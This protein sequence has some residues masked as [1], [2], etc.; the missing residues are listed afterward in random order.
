MHCLTY[1]NFSHIPQNERLKE[2][3]ISVDGGEKQQKIL[4]Q[5]NQEKLVEQNL[6]KIRIAQMDKQIAKQTD[7]AYS[8]ERH[9]M[10]LE[11]AMTDRLIDI[12]SQV[13]LL[14]MKKKCLMEERAQMKADIGDRLMKIEQLKTRYELSM[15]LLGKNDDGSTVTAVQ[16]KIEMAQEKYL[17]LNEGNALNEKILKAENEVK[18]MENMLQLMNFSNDEY[19]KI[20]ETVTESSPEVKKM[21]TLQNNYFQ[22][23]TNIK[24]LKEDLVILIDHLELLEQQRQVMFKDFEEVQRVKLDNNDALLKIHKD[25]VDQETKL[26]RADREMKM[27]FKSAKKRIKDQ[28]FVSLFEKDTRIKEQDERNNSALQQLADLV[29]NTP[30]MSQ[31]VTRHFMERGLSLPAIARRAKSQCSWKSETSL[32]DHSLRGDPHCMKRCECFVREGVNFFHDCV[33]IFFLSQIPIA[34]FCRVRQLH[35]AK[36]W[37]ARRKSQL[38]LPHSNQVYQSSK[39]RSQKPRK[40]RRRR[41][42]FQSA[43]REQHFWNYLFYCERNKT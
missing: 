39:S 32:G 28:E 37:K 6:L 40:H 19:R 3:K 7:K 23:I 42:S 33:K 15:D 13:N 24:I 20:F 43:N 8:L 27:A 1:Q 5:Q 22:A 21:N 10:E 31:N 12:S 18:C 38:K 16:I 36:A 17:L 2:R 30:D 25:L 11:A 14:N 26:E 4:H 9:K 35:Q 34:P 29:E 41:T